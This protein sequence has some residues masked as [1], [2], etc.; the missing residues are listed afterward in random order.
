MYK[1]KQNYL[2]FQSHDIFGDKFQSYP[3]EMQATYWYQVWWIINYFE[4]LM[5]GVDF[6]HHNQRNILRDKWEKLWPFQI[7]NYKIGGAPAMPKMPYT[8]D[9]IHQ[10]GVDYKFNTPAKIEI[11]NLSKSF[12]Q[13]WFSYQVIYGTTIDLF[14]QILNVSNE[15]I[16]AF[17]KPLKDYN[18]KEF[19]IARLRVVSGFVSLADY[20]MKT[21]DDFIQTK[22]FGEWRIK[23]NERMIEEFRKYGDIGEEI[24]EDYPLD[25]TKILDP[26]KLDNRWTR[27]KPFLDIE[28][29]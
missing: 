2:K 20:F 6:E 22:E 13:D 17:L 19:T 24:P 28:K 26:L 5:N 4:T 16:G 8:T 9:V 21:K 23:D 10:L 7:R 14:K 12:K 25:K 3:K 18:P 1:T 15:D 27:E 29:D 11:G